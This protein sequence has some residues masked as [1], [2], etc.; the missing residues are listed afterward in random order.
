MFSDTSGPGN[1]P[2]S[3]T[4]N[5]PS[6]YSNPA[7]DISIPAKT[8]PFSLMQDTAAS[9]KHDVQSIPKWIY[10]IPVVSIGLYLYTKKTK[11]IKLTPY[12]DLK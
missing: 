2:D 9:I 5:L 12:T 7:L 3:L 10:F 8:A 11:R 6:I 4:I 1:T